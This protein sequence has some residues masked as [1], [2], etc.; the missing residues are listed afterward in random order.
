VLPLFDQVSKTLK[1]RLDIRNPDYELRPDM[2][3]DV[4]IP[5]TMPPSLHVPADAVIDSGT[6]SVVYVDMGNGYFEPRPVTTGWRL[7]RQVQITGGLM[8][9]EKVVVS[10]NFLIDS[11]SRMRIAAAGSELEMA[12]DPVCGM[13]VEVGNAVSLER[14]ATHAGKTWYFCMDECRDGF[15]KDPKKYLG[16]EQASGMEHHTDMP[17]MEKSWL[18]ILE[19]TRKGKRRKKQAAVHGKKDGDT[20]IPALTSRGVVDWDGPDPKGEGANRDWT[21]WGKFPGSK[22]L[23]MPQETGKTPEESQEKSSSAPA[24]PG[25]DAKMSHNPHE[26]PTSDQTPVQTPAPA[27]Q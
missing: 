17:G 5:I 21:G 13:Y 11:E 15:Q 25:H 10:G 14:T 4:E 7:G 27:Q 26:L 3:V 12:R 6:K 1:V 18:E 22:Y 19:Q 24:S 9:G 16:K 8:P 23:G 20:F 2:F